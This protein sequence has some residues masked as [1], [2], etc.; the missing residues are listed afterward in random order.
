MIPPKDVV[1]VVLATYL[2]TAPGLLWNRFI[3]GFSQG[4]QD[5][6]SSLNC[7]HQHLDVAF[8]FS[9]APTL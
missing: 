9:L 5:C 7:I 3:H 8:A 6:I 1:L 4:K 2:Q